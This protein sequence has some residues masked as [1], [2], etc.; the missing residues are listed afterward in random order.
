MVAAPL[1][2]ALMLTL[3]RRDLIPAILTTALTSIVVLSPYFLRNALQAGNPMFP[4][5][6]EQF[7]TAHWSHEQVAI[8]SHGHSSDASLTGR[9]Q[10]LWNEFF[11]YGLGV[12][13]DPAEPWQPQW[14]VLPW[15]FLAGW[16][17]GWASRIHRRWFIVIGVALAVQLLFWISFTHLKSR[18]LLPTAV[19]MCIAIGV[20]MNLVLQRFRFQRIIT[21]AVL[22]AM[23]A[24]VALIFVNERGGAPAAATGSA[25]LLNGELL[26]PQDRSA[27]GASTLPAV[28]INYLLP[29]SSR[30]LLIGDAKPFYY[31]ID[32]ISYQTTWD[33]GPLSRVMRAFPDDT[34]RWSDELRQEGFTH[35]LIDASM[36]RR[37]EESGWND[38][39]LTAER[40]L[41][42]ADAHCQ[43]LYRYPNEIT[44]YKLTAK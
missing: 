3:K 15:M 14:A 19:P 22:L 44:L 43:P 18:F 6:T 41:K 17:I 24:F 36:L 16:G 10:A 8:W 39:L 1:G 13:P 37:W 23:N 27:I 38:P 25:R 12:N 34:A 28:A 26:S 42:F 30:V 9:V 32:R 4:F 33:R 31:R 20:G 5:L 21:A 29:E 2:I 35:V 7:G 11:R 40:V